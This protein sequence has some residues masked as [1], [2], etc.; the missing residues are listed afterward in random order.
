MAENGVPL[1]ALYPDSPRA[2]VAQKTDTKELRESVLV[3]EAP[4]SWGAGIYVY[5]GK[6]GIASWR[7]KLGILI[8]SVDIANSLE[9][10]FD[11]AYAHA[12]RIGKPTTLPQDI[13]KKFERS[14]Y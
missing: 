6:V 9:A 1:R 11:A 12:A 3:P 2:R 5:D 4:V 8:E 7:E 10:M 13:S 14:P